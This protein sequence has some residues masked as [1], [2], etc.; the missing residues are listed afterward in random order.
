MLSLPEWRVFGIPD[1]FVTG[2]SIEIQNL[3]V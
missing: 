2:V 3:K 1:L